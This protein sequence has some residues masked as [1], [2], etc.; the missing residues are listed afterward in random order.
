MTL[1]QMTPL[2]GTPSRVNSYRG[3]FSKVGSK[4]L[5][6]GKRGSQDLGKPKSGAVT[7]VE[8]QGILIPSQCYLLNE[9]LLSI[10]VFFKILLMWT[11]FK[12]VFETVAILFLFYV[13]A[14]W[15]QGMWDLSSS[16]RDQTS[17]LCTGRKSLNHWTTRKFLSVSM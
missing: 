8:H 13:S 5:I 15:P 1:R 14:S 4:I 3:K 7:I 9:G 11:I 12:V 2:F 10:S 17:H 6:V 16:T